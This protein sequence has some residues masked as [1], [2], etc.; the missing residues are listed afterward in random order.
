M[1]EE[2][3]GK[4]KKKGKKKTNS[5]QDCEVSKLDALLSGPTIGRGGSEVYQ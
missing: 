1:A 2:G 5:W 4:L 3:V